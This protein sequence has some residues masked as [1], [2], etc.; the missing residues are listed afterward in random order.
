[1]Y[2]NV[3]EIESALAAL[4]AAYPTTSELV[5]TPHA[6][7]EGR[8]THVLRVGAGGAHAADGILLLGGVHAREWVPPDALVAFAAD[9]LEAY[10][11]GTGLGYGGASYAADDVRRLLETRNLFV[12]A[13][14]NPDGRAHSQAV[15]SGWRKN[16]RPAPP[17]STGASCVG[18]DLN[19][20]FDFLWD[21]LAR[22]APDSG[23][24]ASASPCDA[25][26]YRGPSAASEPETRDVVWVLDTYPR[27]RWHVDVHSAV[28]VVLHSWGSDEN[29][30][31]TPGDNFRNTALDPVRGRV[32]DGIGEYLTARDTQVAV[33]LATRLDAGVAAASGASYGVEQAMTLYP[34]SGA[35]DDYAVSRHLVDP[36]RTQVHAWTVE[37]GTSFQ[38][39]YASAEGV[40]REVCS[41]LLAFALAAHEV[42]DGLS[43]VLRTPSVAF[44]DVPEGQ[45]TSR[46]VVVDAQGA[47]DVHLEVVA[48]PTG[49][50]G[51]PLGPVTTV[52]APGVGATTPGRVWLTW[53]AGAPGTP[54]ATASG[55]VTVRC[56]ET[57]QVWTVPVT[58]SAV[59]RSTVGVALVLDRSG[60]MAWDAGDGRSRVEVLREAAS[61]FLEVL[62]AED[63]VGV[64]RFHHDADTAAPVRLAGPETFGPGRAAA[65]AAVA[66]HVPDPAGATSIGDGVLVAAAEL[67]ATAGA[68]DATAMLV[69]TDGQENA[70]AW[71]AD[72]TGALGDRVFA[73]GLGEPAAV[74][75]AAL[76]TL[77]DGSGGWLA[78]SGTLSVD[79]RFLLA[80]Y[81]LQ[82]LAGVTNQQI[83][84]T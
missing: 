76:T 24:S 73:V 27:I 63:G 22:F 7:H 43:A 6:T 47:L 74:D 39:P 20:N 42:T 66:A 1:M 45:T 23:V 78:V 36:A 30:S 15:A 81:F 12:L 18:V 50:F 53:T 79:E 46:A 83:V 21:H 75:P 55:S 57:G 13:C 64:V 51:L 59:P 31:T 44:V 65:L 84:V 26:V 4:A 14:V 37:C 16:R 5:A 41:G 3:T 61:V 28:P 77:V 2:L 82:V 10:A 72:V 49:P 58:A 69:L 71:L 19:R 70:P 17:G 8:T 34:T 54:A 35:S 67:A 32:G 40:I 9:L 38:P 62:P 11:T 52:P 25:N 33:E 80:Q 29:Q 48:G 68:F 56:V 60:S